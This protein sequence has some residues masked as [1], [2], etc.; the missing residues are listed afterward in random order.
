[1]LPRA[2]GFFEDDP[3][4]RAARRRRRR[5]ERR[6]RR[7]D[8]RQDRRS[9][10]DR[11]RPASFR[12]VPF[13]VDEAAGE[14]GRRYQHHE[15]PQRNVPWAE[16]LGRS[17]RRWQ[18]TG[19]VLGAHYMGTRDRLLAAC[20]QPGAGTLV[21]PYL[22]RLQVVCESVRYRERNDEGGMCRLEL[23]FAEP[24]TQGAPDARRAAGAAL[25][26]AARGLATAARSAF[27]G[28]TFRVAGFPDFVARAAA[29]D[30]AELA[31]ILDALRG[32]TLQVADPIAIAA[33]R[34]ILALAALTPEA[35]SADT[36]AAAVLD[37]VDA[38]TSSVTAA[39]ALDGLTAL[40]LVTFTGPPTTPT[41]A[42]LQEAENAQSLTALTHQAA[43]AALPGAVSAVPLTSYDDVVQV[44]TRVVDLCDR[45]EADATDAV[46]EALADVRA[47]AVADLAVRGATLRPLRPYQT[48][49]PRPSLTLAHQLYQDATRA[50]ELVART[51][52]PHPGFLPEVGLVAAA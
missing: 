29:H 40:T 51:R 10:R 11:L 33:R 23:A 47:Q 25:R 31:R 49:F 32:P 24:G 19:Y 36:I 7:A 15:Y 21:H 27:A 30:L 18:L 46:Y 1:M 41:P 26:G 4:P 50:D 17:Q 44:R 16:D 12:G 35:V 45:V 38:F 48:A 39:V 13:H 14:Y 5:E 9:W 22:G 34:R 3:H 2:V 43:A 37:A 8:R 42:R 52:A 20:E 6:D 28:N